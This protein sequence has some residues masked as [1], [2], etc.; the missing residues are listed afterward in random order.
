MTPE[1]QAEIERKHACTM[2][3]ARACDA[4]EVFTALRE[5][6][7]EL[8]PTN[9]WWNARSAWYQGE[10]ERLQRRVEALEKAIKN[11]SSCGSHHLEL[12]AALRG[13]GPDTCNHEPTCARPHERSRGTGCA[14]SP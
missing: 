1:R 10:V 13:T 2:K 4:C 3:W 5:A 12:F 8:E 14:T 6:Q 7:P 9:E 11:I